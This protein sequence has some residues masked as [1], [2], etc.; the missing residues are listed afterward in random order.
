MQLDQKHLL[1]FGGINR[2]T[3]YDDVWVLNVADKKWEQ[4]NIEGPCPAARAHHTAT[5]C[6]NKILVFGGYAGNGRALGDLWILHLS[7]DCVPLRWEEA[8]LS[9]APPTPRFDHCAFIFPVTPN[10]STFDKYMIMGGRDNSSQ[11]S[12]SYML[13][14]NKMAWESDAKPPALTYELCNNLCDDVESVPYHK[15][16]T[17]GGKRGATD[18]QNVVEVMDCGMQFWHQPEVQGTPPCPRYLE[19]ANCSHVA[20]INALLSKATLM[21]HLQP[22]QVRSLLTSVLSLKLA[23]TAHSGGVHEPS[24]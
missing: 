16:F 10:S 22:L 1:I 14:L 12:D 24:T 21:C 6:G 15:V 11:F 23:L 19:T 8:L 4:P 5:K 9:G 18:F 17:F 3:R 7:E 20:G 2:R 13:D